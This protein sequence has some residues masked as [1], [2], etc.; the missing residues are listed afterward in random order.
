[1]SLWVFPVILLTLEP[2]IVAE[3]FS[4]FVS[5]QTALMRKTMLQPLG[6]LGGMRLDGW[7]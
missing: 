4:R 2:C 3:T 1:M 7:V 6:V 5:D